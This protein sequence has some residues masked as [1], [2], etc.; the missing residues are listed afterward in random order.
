MP[1]T[2]VGPT[3]TPKSIL[4]SKTFWGLV[5]ALAM[6]TLAKHGVIVDPTGLTGDLSTTIGAA[7]ALYGR[8]SAS[9]PVKL[10]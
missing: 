6:P 7:L 4:E 10:I 5:V 8:F 2:P 9:G 3:S 1:D